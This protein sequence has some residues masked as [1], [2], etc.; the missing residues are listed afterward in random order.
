MKKILGLLFALMPAAAAAQELPPKVLFQVM[1]ETA[2]ILSRQLPKKVDEYT[3]LLS[4]MALPRGLLYNFRVEVS[5]DDV[6]P[7]AVEKFRKTQIEAHCEAP[8]S[9]KFMSLGAGYRK[10]Y[11][12]KTGRYLFTVDITMADCR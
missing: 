10:M 2:A 8:E 4:V 7:D 3:T 12:D 5:K 11:T 9:L 6:R 1:E